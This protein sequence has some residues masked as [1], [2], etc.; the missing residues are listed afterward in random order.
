MRCP[1]NDGGRICRGGK[2]TLSR[3]AEQS[4]ASSIMWSLIKKA[5]PYEKKRIEWRVGYANNNEVTQISVIQRN[6]SSEESRKKTISNGNEQR[7]TESPRGTHTTVIQSR[8]NVLRR[9]QKNKAV[10]E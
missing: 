2:D 8:M 4:E 6:A 3:H 9:I 7:L 10:K 1:L 5:T